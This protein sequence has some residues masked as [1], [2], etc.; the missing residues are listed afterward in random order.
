MQDLHADPLAQRILRDK[1]SQPS[2]PA[3]TLPREDG[4][5]SGG[6]ALDELLRFAADT[7][8]RDERYRAE[9]DITAARQ[10]GF[11]DGF[12]AGVEL[13]LRRLRDTLRND[14]IPKA[15][16]AKGR[17]SLL[18]GVIEQGVKPGKPLK[19]DWC[20][21]LKDQAEAVPL[22]CDEVLDALESLFPVE[23]VEETFRGWTSQGWDK[24]TDELFFRR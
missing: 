14:V 9:V 3:I 13:T 7:A 22:L 11:D 8:R 6:P 15:S 4:S 10:G 21:D 20:D 23:A 5:G 2:T 24:D 18:G 1:P 17:A 12:R 16:A 19:G